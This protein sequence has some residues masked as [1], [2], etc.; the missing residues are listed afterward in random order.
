[1]CSFSVSLEFNDGGGERL[2]HSNPLWHTAPVP[3]AVTPGMRGTR[4]A[5]TPRGMRR[6]DMAAAERDG[7]RRSG[8][9]RVNDILC[10]YAL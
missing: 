10:I 4:N 6:A 5:M 3:C 7:G 2:T 8:S 1:M 9:G